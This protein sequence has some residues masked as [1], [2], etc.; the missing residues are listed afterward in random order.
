VSLKPDLFE[1][2]RFD[3]TRPLNQKFSLQHSLFMGSVEARRRLRCLQLPTSSGRT[4]SIR[5]CTS[6]EALLLPTL[7]PPIRAS[8]IVKLTLCAVLVCQ[9]MLI[10]RL[11]T[12][13][14]LSA[15]IK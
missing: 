5:R 12:D 1:G 6:T 14:R 10:G 4:S 8:H 15:R 2:C 13:G 7:H 3:F 11:L 9:G